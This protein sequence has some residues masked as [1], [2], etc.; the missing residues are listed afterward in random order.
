[1]ALIGRQLT[2]GNY[3]KLDDISSQFNSSTK[4]F[5]LTTAGQPF[6]PGSVFSILV[7]VANVIQEPATSYTIDQATITFASAPTTGSTFFCIV[8]G[9]AFGVG[10]PADGT[11]TG[12]KLSS[13]FNYNS[14]LLYL[15][16][17][18]NRVGILST[19]PTVTLDVVGNAKVSGT[20]NL[21]GLSVSGITTLSNTTIFN[22]GPVLVGTATST[23]TANQKLQVSGGAYVSSGLGI[24]T[25]TP[26]GLLDVS[27]G[28]IRVRNNGTYTEPLDNA[29]VL[30]YDSNLSEFTVSSRSSSTNSYL[31]FLTS[32]SGTSGERLRI[33]A[34]GNLLVGTAF[35]T[36][37]ASQP[38]QVSGGA[39]VSANLGVGRANPTY[40]I[41]VFGG[42]GLR[43][44]G[45]SGDG[46]LLAYDT[47]SGNN[48]ILEA[49]DF[50][51]TTKRNLTIQPNGGNVLVGAAT[52]TGT[53]SQP[54]QVTGGAY[55]SGNVGIGTTRPQYK[56]DVLGDINFTGTFYQNSSAFVASRWTAGTGNNI[57]RLSGNVG[58][59]TT[60]PIGQLQVSSG[61]VI[62]GAATST[63]TAS[64]PLQVSGGAYVSGNV[65]IGTTNPTT[66]L[67]VNGTITASGS[68]VFQ[69]AIN[70]NTY[71]FRGLSGIIT[72]DSGSVYPT[73]WNLQYGNT[74]SSALYINSSGNVL[75]NTTSAT[76]TASQ[77]LQVTGGAYVSGNVGIGTTNPS[78]KLQVQNG[79]IL[80]KGAA[81]P[82]INFEPAGSLGNADISFDGTTFNVVSNSSS[83][84]LVLGTYSAERLRIT[85]IGNVGIGT[86]SPAE[87]LHIHNPNTS[88]AVIRLSGSAV[89]QTPFNIRQ[90]I[91]GT[92]NAGFSI[93]DVNN[94]A[95]RFAIDSSGNVGIGTNNPGSKLTVAGQFQS[96]QAN[97]TTTG[98]GQIYLNGAT[99][100]RIDFAGVGYATPA[101][102]TRSVGTKIVL[103]PQITASNVDYAIGVENTAIWSS[104]PSSASQFKW[105]AGTTNIATLFGT[106]QLVLG[107]TS[108]TGTAS[109]PLQVT[110]GAYVSGNLGV[111]VT[112]P[113]SKLDIVGDIRFG[114]QDYSFQS[115]QKVATLNADG[116]SGVY[117]T[118][119]FR[120]YTYP[121]YINTS[122]LKLGIRG[123]DDVLGETSDLVTIVS[124]SAT[125]GN[126]GIG[127]T[128]PSQ[129][130]HVQGNARITGELYD[131]NNGAG[132]TGQILQSVG[133]GISWTT[134]S[135]GSTV[136]VSDDTTTNAT[137]YLVFE[138]VTSGT[139]S[140]INVSST[141]LTF[142]PSTGAL[143]ATDFNSTSDINLKENIKPI[144]NSL[145]KIMQLNG[146]E[147]DW[148]ENKKPSIG[149][150]A[151]EV[152]KVFP[153]LVK[154]AENK[155]VNYNGLVGV[156]IEAIKELKKEVEEL[157][158][159][160]YT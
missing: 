115:I 101:T 22:P 109:Q 156:L 66:K 25:A 24:G 87:N 31:R 133:T 46:Y 111:G 99:G 8:L 49:T 60:N 2:S 144:E 88:L 96:T 80:V 72:L 86:T 142:N 117:P 148:K 120:F 75:I 121:G 10:V 91:V 135:G 139:S 114:K 23:G 27:G 119:S 20:T 37:T 134:F 65:G 90:G 21:N 38:L 97:S 127:T 64:Q 147:F 118:G 82:N 62:I 77:P 79:G 100:N 45:V 5:N 58:I 126:I 106:G 3:Q 140:S 131:F 29:G 17:A 158:I 68:I 160:K 6:Y 55:V 35:S 11:V 89:S 104:V 125:S 78:Q 150:I 138:D 16:T 132:S 157:K 48:V 159:A 69:D 57:Y 39:Y 136:T 151:Q 44:G 94:S 7:S 18:N 81:T 149:V 113:G 137:R 32:N 71:G 128:N 141:K 9:T 56:L 19:S 14:G 73:G 26:S 70:T 102:T 34:E 47:S 42:S 61:P 103:D 54:L 129:K 116:I 4:T 40:K 28:T 130:L 83:A 143:S 52:S 95:T 93:Y 122:T 51:T 74:S 13:P 63:G 124:T 146:I 84:V 76:G 155:S 15:D 105:Y 50:L 153:S 154:T 1:M 85:A 108:L 110:G 152:E 145:D 59:G 53:A 30:A 12:T 92:S 67:D 41:D 36:G 123:Q 43:V 98:G 33:T 112:N 107:T